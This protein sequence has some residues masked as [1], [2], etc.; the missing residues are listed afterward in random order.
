[1]TRSHRL[2]RQAIVV[3][4]V[5]FVATP[6]SHAQDQSRNTFAPTWANQAGATVFAEK[7]CGLC[8]A[9]RELGATAGPNRS[10]IERRSFFDLGAAMSNHLRGVNIRKPTL[11]AD[12]V[13]SRIS[14]FLFTL[15]YGN[16]AGD[17]TA[18][19]ALFTSKSGE[20]VAALWN[21]PPATSRSSGRKCS[22]LSSPVRN[23]Q[24]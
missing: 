17:P 15:Q 19:Q 14:S 8:H 11:S 23:W 13:N 10:R 4:L 9:I 2:L 24:T 5:I 18:G 6:L 1:M 22:G 21:H 3:S 16:P 7:G 12:E 20:V